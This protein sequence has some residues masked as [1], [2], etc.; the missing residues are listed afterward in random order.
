MIIIIAIILG[1]IGGYFVPY[2]MPSDITNYIAIAILA[3]FDTLFGGIY[4]DLMQK[5]DTKLYISGFF[6]NSFLACVII[7]IGNIIGVDLSVAAIVVFGS[8]LFNNFSKIRQ[9]LLHKD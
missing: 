2:S 8:R 4:A 6:L 3:C 5:F 9:K 7:F 1:F